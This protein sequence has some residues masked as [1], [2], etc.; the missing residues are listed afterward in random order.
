MHLT[1]LCAAPAAAWVP[2]E[3]VCTRRPC[4][5]PPQSLRAALAAAWVPCAHACMR[6]PCCTTSCLLRAAPGITSTP[7]EHACM[8]ALCTL[9]MPWPPQQQRG[10]WELACTRCACYAASRSPPWRRH[11]AVGGRT[12]ALDLLCS[13]TLIASCPVSSTRRAARHSDGPGSTDQSTDRPIDRRWRTDIYYEK[14]L[15]KTD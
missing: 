15:K 4:C 9:M 2:C 7:W 8:H 12:H 10:R 11:S 5:G 14:L 13:L 3:L 1:W 6:W